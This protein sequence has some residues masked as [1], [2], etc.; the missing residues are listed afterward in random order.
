MSTIEQFESKFIPEAITGCWLWTA[1]TCRGYG[2]FS[3]SGKYIRA[4]RFSYEFYKGSVP[5]GLVLDHL[6][7][8]RSCVNPDHLEAVTDKENVL[9]GEGPTARN[10]AKTHCPR[11]HEYTVIA[12]G[13]RF[14]KTCKNAWTR[15][16]R[17]SRTV[18][19]RK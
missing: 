11:G 5:K 2:R 17:P 19:P 4:H 8:N 9:R 10:K 3:L 15:A 1:N 14:C 18:R 16:N 12:E 6:C 7:R 13:N